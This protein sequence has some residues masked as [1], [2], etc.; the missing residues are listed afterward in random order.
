MH[1]IYQAILKGEGEQID[2]KQTISSASKIAKT[3]VSFANHKG[4]RLLVGVRDNKSISGI[5]SEDEK[6]MLDL[7]A[8]F[9]CKPELNITINEWQLEG[10]IVIEAIIPEGDKKPYFAKDEEGKWWAYVRVAD[11]S[12]LASKIS[13][14]VMRKERIGKPSLIVYGPKEKGLIDII[15]TNGRTTM[16]EYAKKMNIS[17]WRA[18]KIIIKMIYA[19]VI[20]SHNTEKT[21]Y[22]TLT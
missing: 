18:S 9:Y 1:P 6:Y 19:G 20:R 7:A 21:E 4:G 5:R 10:R 13:L 2:F 22:Y 15:K 16:K 14:E 12:L 8:G 17:T 3:M 11:Q